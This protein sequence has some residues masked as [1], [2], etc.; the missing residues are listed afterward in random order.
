MLRSSQ[1]L[2]LIVLIGGAR[3]VA[4]QTTDDDTNTHN[5][6]NAAVAFAIGAF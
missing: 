5:F 3:L 2:V 4:T 6:V 1:Y